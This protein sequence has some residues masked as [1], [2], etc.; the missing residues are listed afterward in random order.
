MA[1]KGKH[2][3]EHG[4][5]RPS[6]K[7]GWILAGILIALVLVF[8]LSLALG[9]GILKSSE[10]TS[11]PASESSEGTDALNDSEDTETMET[12]GESGDSAP[13]AELELE[14]Q[15]DAPYEHWLAAAV[16]SGIS[17]NYPDFESVVYY[18]FGT[19]ELSASDDSGGI[20]VT[21]T[22]GG[23]RLC[24]YASPLQE[25]RT[26]AGTLDIYSEVI[27]YA[28]FDLVDESNI[29]ADYAEMTIDD[30]N[31]LITQSVRIMLYEH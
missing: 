18:A 29:P 7:T 12:E 1:Y 16:I 17:M 31:D 3:G 8:I 25:E 4:N 10:S 27:G 26:E 19:T 13:A 21:F 2:T 28:T 6:R 30:L 5:K 23:E 15:D 14:T 24:V 20:Y 11:E 9:K 22:S